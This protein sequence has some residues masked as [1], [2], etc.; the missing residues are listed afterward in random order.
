M[1]KKACALSCVIGWSA[2]WTFG[3]LALSA[4]P[5]QGGQASVAALLAA[6]GFLTGM[7]TYVRLGRETAF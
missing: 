3:Y 7:F 5:D 6:A 1:Q 2:F 4:S